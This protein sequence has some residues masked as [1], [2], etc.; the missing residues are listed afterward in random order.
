[1][2]TPPKQGER[3][4]LQKDIKGK[5]ITYYWC[6]PHRDGKGLWVQHKKSECRLSKDKQQDKKNDKAPPTL[7]A[8]VAIDDDEDDFV[9]G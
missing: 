7:Q 2:T 6:P 4:T 8:N 5:K 9:Q 1:M 3:H